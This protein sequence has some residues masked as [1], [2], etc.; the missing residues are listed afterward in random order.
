MVG[1]F[2]PFPRVGPL[3]KQRI[4]DSWTLAI[5]RSYHFMRK[6]TLGFT[7]SEASETP[8]FSFGVLISDCHFIDLPVDLQHFFQRPVPWCLTQIQGIMVQL[9]RIPREGISSA[10]NNGGVHGVFFKC[11]L[12]RLPSFFVVWDF[13]KMAVALSSCSEIHYSQR[14]ISGRSTTLKSWV[15]GCRFQSFCVYDYITLTIH[16]I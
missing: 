14:E 16:I 5:R 3:G 13:M 7:A 15:N 9:V 6:R 2:E 11:S 8:M 4:L 1:N 12:M 10:I